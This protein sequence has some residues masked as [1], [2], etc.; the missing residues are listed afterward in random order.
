MKAVILAGGFG[1]RLRSVTND[2][3]PK[4]MV[5]VMDRPIISYVVNKM[6]SQSIT[7]ITLALH[8]KPEPIISYYGD[9]IKYKVEEVPLGTGGAI[10]NC[11]DGPDLV[12]VCNGDTVAGIDYN[13]ML[14]NYSYPLT[15]AQTPDGISAGIYI[16]NP[17]ILDGFDG[18]FSFEEDVIP[19]TEHTFYTIPW[20]TDVG[21]EE[22]YKSC[23]V[24]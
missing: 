1:T 22:G 7:D 15:I 8:Y 13:K 10:K 20:F 23:D 9:S 3:I 18:A 6:R 19:K 21:T 17:C 24:S 12:L 5:R 14:D 4:C 2:L 16:M 11:I